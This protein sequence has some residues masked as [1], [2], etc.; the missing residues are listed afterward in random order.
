MRKNKG[1]T[2]VEL[3]AMLV[4]LGIL[5]AVAIPNITGI[6]GNQ[7][8]NGYKQDA[9]N[10][11]ET[12][13]TKVAKDT[14][15]DKP[16][17]GQCLYFTLDS[18]DDNDNFSSGPNGGSYEQY[19]SMV[20]MTRVETNATTHT[21]KFKY[22]VRLLEKDKDNYVGI[23]LIDSDDIKEIKNKDIKRIT[24]MYDVTK[25]RTA[26][27]SKLNNIFRTGG[28]QPVTCNATTSKYYTHLKRVCEIVNGQYYGKEGLT[29]TA[30][31]YAI[32]CS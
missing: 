32:E 17:V 19:E 3:L 29:V 4:I 12:A 31:Q 13:K 20:I 2:L 23:E 5:M 24:T 6:L 9:I 7:R 26:S 27:L 14:T 15:I 21:N 11:V 25:D 10:M 18:I 22:Y 1:F 16:N 8:L 30:E 28:G